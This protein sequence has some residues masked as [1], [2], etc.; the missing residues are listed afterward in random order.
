MITIF[1][2]A[3]V[4]SRGAAEFFVRVDR[5][6]LLNYVPIPIGQVT[7][8]ECGPAPAE[9]KNVAAG[10]SRRLNDWGDVGA[11]ILSCFNFPL[12]FCLVLGITSP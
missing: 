2:D 7:P 10:F 5:E 8:L 11:L 1:D 4:L 12:A 6:A 3:E 9:G